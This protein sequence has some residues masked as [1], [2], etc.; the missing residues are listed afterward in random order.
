MRTLMLKLYDFLSA[1]RK[2]AAAGWLAVMGVC[3]FLAFRLQYSE[4]IRSFLPSD[5]VSERYSQVYEK[6]GG[7][8]RVA[9]LFRG[10]D[11]DTILEAMEGFEQEWLAGAG[12]EMVP[13]LRAASVD[14]AAAQQLLTFVSDQMP[15]FLTQADYR[16]IDSLLA[17]PGYIADRLDRIR[18]AL[19]A[20]VSFRSPFLRSDP[21]D[22]FSPVYRRLETLRP[23]RGARL[24]DGCL[25]TPDG[26]C[27]ILLFDSPYGGSESGRN[28]ALS[29]AVDETAAATMGAFPGVVISAT[30][31]PLVA[32]TNARTLKR[33]SFLALGLAMLLICLVLFFSYK[34]LADVLWMALSLL[35]GGLFAVGMIA[36]LRDTVSIIV[37]GIGSTLLGIAANYPLHYIDHLKYQPDRRKALRDQIHPLLTGNITTVGAF[38]SLTFLRSEALRDFG[39][40]GALMLVGTILFVLVFLPVFI[41]LPKRPRNTLQLDPAPYFHFLEGRRT[42]VFGAF[43][44]LTLLLAWQ[45]RKVGFDTDMGHINLMTAAQR[46]GFHTLE[47]MGGGNSLFIVR[48][49]TDPQQVLAE[50]AASDTLMAPYGTLRT[51]TPFLPTKAEQE[52]R[53]AGW[54]A[55]RAAHPQLPETLRKAAV[56]GGF[57]ADAFQPFLERWERPYPVRELSHFTPLLRTAGR[58]MYLSDDDNILLVSYLD[59]PQADK[60]TLRAALPEGA[61][62]FDT[63]DVSGNLARLLSADFDRVGLY[64]SLIVFLFLCLSFGSLELSL[65]AFLPL[66]VGWVWILGLM[67]L[68]GLQFN[69][70]NIILAAFIFGMGDDYSIFITEGLVYERATGKKILPSFRNS[71]VLSALIMFI[72]IGTLIT[73]RHP[74][75]R[76][77]A[78]VTVIG[79]ATVVLMACYL[80]P[81]VFRWL[82]RDRLIPLTLRQIGVTVLSFTVFLLT[83]LGCSLWA[84]GLFLLRPAGPRRDER[85]HRGINRICRTAL[86]YIPDAPHTLSNSHGEDFSRP[87]VL[88]CNHQ[89][90]LDLLSLL[91]LHPKIIV[92]TND[93]AWNNPFYGFLIRRAGFLPVSLGWEQLI[94]R[95]REKVEQGYSIAVF[96]EG[97]RSPDGRIGRFH[98]GAFLMARE[99]GLDI[100]PVYLHGFGYVLPKQYF[101]MHKAGL[102]TEIGARISDISDDIAAFSR[103]M[104]RHYI[105]E[106]TR[107][108]RERET[109]AYLAPFVRYQYVYK[110]SEAAAECRK[111]LNDTVF[112][113]I[114]ALRGTAS[115]RVENSGCG[116][117]ALLLA[118][119][120]PDMTVY[121]VEADEDKALTGACCAGRPA[122]LLSEDRPAEKV[123]VL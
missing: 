33:D 102:Y 95:L 51:L 48:E 2:T 50:A 29:R 24:E 18:E 94:P 74:A 114:D 87:S 69:I 113:E 59:A 123:I 68:C 73:A 63:E 96:P 49:G 27:G 82:T 88:V 104:R 45:S 85:Y 20:P 62:C 40:I 119:T 26:R 106:Y 72:G 15:Y 103:E 66:A 8:E 17:R 120:H 111:Y 71:V 16:R 65:T 77:L 110:G 89:S 105:R 22:L 90:H 21:L 6:L 92:L 75:L 11:P 98:R 35:S 55:L 32:V 107:I 34:R 121:A 30:G 12:G 36:L 10:E 54:E 25:F 67:G 83:M 14:E 70:V 52:R 31:G 58:S 1:H 122:N 13:D 112:R 23:A 5:P 115:V 97:T 57:T 93:W 38:L 108:R 116:V 118:L 86:R 7:Q 60:Q 39:A 9:I 61:F 84:V 41:T 3:A 76:S 42:W 4:D 43:L 64:C 100:L 47:T 79:M 53:L 81:L 46:D 101:M 19:S 99:L 28:T 91:A 44:L 78:E 37:L 109:A 56:E 117:Y 80:P